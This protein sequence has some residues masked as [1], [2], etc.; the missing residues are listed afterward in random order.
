M[1]AFFKMGVDSRTGLGVSATNGPLGSVV[2]LYLFPSSI[3]EI[4]G[5][6]LIS[7]T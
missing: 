3:P 4:A 5:T 2:P 7:V 6:L 1:A